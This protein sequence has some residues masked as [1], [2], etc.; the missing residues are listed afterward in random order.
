MESTSLLYKTLVQVLS[1]HQNWLDVR[2][3]KTLAWMINGLILSGK[4]SLQA[5]AIYVQSRAKYVQSTIRRFRRFLDNDRIKVHPLYAPLLI[6]A[7]QGWDGKRVYV[8]LD[9]SML[10]NTYCLVRLSLIYRG[11]AVPIV[12]NVLEQASASVAFEEYQALL[13]RAA[14]LLFPFGLKITFLADR[15]FADTDLMQHLLDLGW[16]FRIR[17]KESFWIYPPGKRPRQ[18][19]HIRLAAG[20]TQFF[21]NVQITKER[22]GP[23]HLAIG[24]P[25][26]S[27]ERWVL[28]S[29]EPTSLETFQDYGLRFDIEENFLDDKSNGF[30]LEASLI[31]SAKALERLCFVLAL[32]T[33]YL[34]ARGV[35]VVKTNKRRLVDPHWF[36]GSSYL[37]IGWNWIKRALSKGEH[38][39]TCLALSP[40]PDPEVAMASKKQH[41]KRTQPRFLLELP[42][43][44]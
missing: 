12:W 24:R 30:Q 5:W 41:L 2:H 35:Q 21:H 1:C 37:K 36:R 44:A 7:L 8:A 31:R 34:I 6:Q 40:E 9:T 13:D 33:L 4:I 23:L 26:K 17:I 16:H 14:Q 11:R 42:K 39:S 18:V 27:R 15:G 10:F 25:L 3:L 43:A 32:T 19:K 28:I 22:V 38:L 20:H 29:D